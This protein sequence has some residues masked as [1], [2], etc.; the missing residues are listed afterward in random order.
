MRLSIKNR[1]AGIFISGILVLSSCSQSNNNTA[2][3]PL[4]RDPVYDGA[5][6]PVVVWNEQEA[7]WY[8][9]YTNRRANVPGLDGVT[10]VHGTRIGIAS[11]EHGASW[12]YVDTANINYR[13]FSEYTHWAPEVIRHG[14]LYHMYL[15]YVPG[16]FRDWRHPRDIVHLTSTN[17]TDWEY[18]STIQLASGRVIDACVV[19][20]PGGVWRM[21]YNN[22]VDGKSI[23]YADSPDLYSWTDKGKAVGDQGGEGPKVFWWEDKWWMITDVWEGLAVY[24]SSDLVQWKRQESNLLD[25]PGEGEYDRTVGHHPDV[26][27]NSGKAY[28]FYFVHPFR[29]NKPE[30]DISF[31]DRRSLIQVTELHYEN[32]RLTCKRDKPTIINL[33]SAEKYEID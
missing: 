18:Q 1:L 32:G 15:T 16:I 30:Q 12:E 33:G 20:L 9:F 3:K 17:L 31:P 8:M 6:D 2:D 10:W 22:E 29:G 21:W 26:V 14:D 5:A 23:Y 4:F 11:S 24:S 25:K 19:R 27:V 13:P 28:L 7:K